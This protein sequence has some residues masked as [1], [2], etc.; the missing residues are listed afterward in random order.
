VKVTATVNGRDVELE[1]S[2]DM[3]SPGV[4][5]GILRGETY[6]IIPDLGPVR[7]VLDVGANVGAASVLFACHY[8]DA[9]IHSF[10]PGPQTYEL[11]ARNTAPFASIVTHPFGL[12]DRNETRPLYRGKGS[13]GEASIFKFAWVSDESD[14]VELRSAAEWADEAGIESIDVLKIDTEGCEL[15]ILQ[16]L[17][18]LLPTVQVLYVEFNSKDAWRELDRVL[19]DTHELFGAS[20]LFESGELLYLSK[21]RYRRFGE[22]VERASREQ[23]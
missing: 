11:L 21:D 13:P 10:E 1:T 18:A 15:P 5:K 16:A 9:T 2:N 23:P 6:R 4:T 20:V 7:T 3:V 17:A 12:F 22:Q 19:A 14:V 8:P